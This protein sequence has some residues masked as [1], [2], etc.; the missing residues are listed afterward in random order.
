MA[1]FRRAHC[2]SGLSRGAQTDILSLLVPKLGGGAL[3][4]TSGLSHTVVSKFVR[5]PLIGAWIPTSLLENP[6]GA[7]FCLESCGAK[8]SYLTHCP[9]AAIICPGKPK[10]GCANHHRGCSTVESGIQDH[11]SDG[12]GIVQLWSLAVIAGDGATTRLVA[13]QSPTNADVDLKPYR[14]KGGISCSEE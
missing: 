8:P 3:G 14:D 10:S 12:T 1:R 4:F 6:T 11:P 5:A 13:T 7:D 9:P 2:T